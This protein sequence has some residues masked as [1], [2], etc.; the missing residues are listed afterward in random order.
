[1][2][3]ILFGSDGGRRGGSS[4]PGLGLSSLSEPVV[5]LAVDN[6]QVAKTSGSGGATTDGLLRPLREKRRDN[7]YPMAAQNVCPFSN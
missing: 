4:L 3:K 6:L 1:M 5:E 2:K 7:Y